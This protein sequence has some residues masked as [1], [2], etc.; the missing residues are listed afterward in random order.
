LYFRAVVDDFRFPPRVAE[1]RE[2][3]ESEAEEAGAAA[4]HERLVDLDPVAAARIEPANAR[5]TIRALEVIEVTGAPFSSADSWDRFESIFDL[6]VVGLTLARDALYT[7][8]ATR[9]DRMLEEGLVDEARALAAAG[10]GRTA[11]QALGYRQVLDAT[12]PND[13]DAIRANI[14]RATKRFARRQESW[15]KADPRIEWI[16]AADPNVSEKVLAVLRNRERA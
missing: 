2:R 12:D 4:M 5:R 6:R 11:R 9:V 7:R 13:I 16:D 15:F 10:L 1:V 3:L 8:I 14:V